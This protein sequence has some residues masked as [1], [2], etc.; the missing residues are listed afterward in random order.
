MRKTFLDISYTNI[1][2]SFPSLYQCI[3][4]RKHRSLLTAVLA[5]FATR[6][7]SS[8]TFERPE[9]ISRTSCEPL[10]ATNT[11]HRKQETF[12][13][14]YPLH[15]VFLPTETY[16]R[17][18]LFS[19]TFL[20]EGRD[21]DYWTRPLNMRMRVFYLDCHEAGLCCYLVTDIENL[22]VHYSCFTCICDIFTTLRHELPKSVHSASE[23]GLKPG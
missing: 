13:C 6:R 10:Y 18:L 7:A 4:T 17:T 2:T 11:S 9:R 20:K 1:D 8:A 16:I 5:T 14:E 23:R 3:Q 19:S 15:W 21:F 22:L 12:L